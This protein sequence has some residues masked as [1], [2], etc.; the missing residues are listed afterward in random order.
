MG[1]KLHLKRW[2]D[3]NKL[4]GKQSGDRSEEKMNNDVLLV[5]P[6]PNTQ[7]TGSALVT[8]ATAS[9]KNTARHGGRNVA[10]RTLE[11][12]KDKAMS[13]ESCISKASHDAWTPNQLNEFDVER[14]LEALA[15]YRAVHTCQ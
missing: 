1:C 4:P 8:Q 14:P 13:L 7:R 12:I 3:G 5:E 6:F 2:S 11:M 10:K 15:W 9:T